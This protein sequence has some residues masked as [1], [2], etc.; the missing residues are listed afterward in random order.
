MDLTIRQAIPGDL[1]GLLRFQQGVVEA[2]R[3][4][5]P[6]IKDGRVEYYDVAA[7]MSSPDVHFLV[8]ECGSDLV[9]CGYARIEAAK[10]YL[11]HPMHAYLG[12]MYVD[13]ARRGQAVIGKI[14]DALKTWCRARQITEL[15]L[16]VYSGNR[17]AI[18][19]YQKAGF[20][21]HVLEMRLGL[22]DVMAKTD[23]QAKTDAQAKT[24]AQ[25]KT[26]GS[27]KR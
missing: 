27:A 2:E 22:T 3:A 25:A 19:A 5:D 1:A 12:L 11:K 10:H 6:T 16:D 8:A 23:V 24:G 26:D 20:A 4:F 18:R 7:L 21:E 17:A 15:R 14:I 9:G 13:P